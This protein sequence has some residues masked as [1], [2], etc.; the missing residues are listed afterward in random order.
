VSISLLTAAAGGTDRRGVASF[1]G[2]GCK[3]LFGALV[4]VMIMPGAASAS[5]SLVPEDTAA[6]A[7][8]VYALDVV[9]GRAIIGGL[10]TGVGGQARSN[11]AA[12]TADGKVDKVFNPGA[13]GQVKAVAASEDGSVIFLGGLFTEAGGAQRANLAAVDA[14]TGEALAEWQA[15]TAGTNPDVTS[16]AVHGNR[17]Y[18]GGRFARIDGRRYSRMVALNAST[19]ELLTGFQPAPDNKVTE[20]VV[21]PDGMTVYAGGAFSVLGGQPRLRAGSV[22]AITGSATSFSPSGS[23]G[24]A[25]T[26]GLSPD[27]QRFFVGTQNNTLFA[28]DSAVS[29]A[30]VWSIK[31]SGDTQAIAV[32]DDEMW[33]GG[34]FSQIVTG[35]I[36]RP[37]IASLDPVDGSVNAWNPQCAGPKMGVWALQHDGSHLHAGGLFASFN[38]VRQRGYAR[39]AELP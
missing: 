14:V 19:G 35:K 20:V 1:V 38:G 28:Y 11:V 12:I 27:G 36:P 37:F 25:V 39:F 31:T 22:D 17:L 24:N 5:V 16:L 30:P 2:K 32:S 21:S 23:G 10:F 7:G 26:V 18:V 8:E 33:I 9:D 29:N 4:L 3:A 6:A 15:D 34:H 13:N